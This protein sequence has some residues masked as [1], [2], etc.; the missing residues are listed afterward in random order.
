M[1]QLL[2]KIRIARADTHIMQ[3]SQKVAGG[4]MRQWYHFMPQTGWMN[5]PN[6]LIWFRDQYHLFYQYNPY[7]AFWGMMYWGHAVSN[8]LIH[9]QHLPLALAPGHFYDDHPKGGCFSGSAI[10]HDGKLW[11][12]YTGTYYQG[13]GFRQ[14]QCAAW[15]QDGIHFEKY[16]GNPVLVP[17]E[18]YDLSNF[19]DPKVF[20][21]QGKFY[22]VVGAKREG[23][24]RA[25][26]FRSDDLLHW[27]FVNV[28]A[29]SRGELGYM[30]ECPDFYPLGDNGLYVLMFSP[31]GL[32]QR[33]TLYL[34]GDM[35]FDRGIFDSHISGEVD[36]GFDY[37]APQSFLDGKGRRILIAWANAWDWMPWWKDWGPTYT[38]G[39]CGALTLPR[40]V[41][42]LPDHT[43]A[44]QPVE[45]VKGLRGPL[46]NAGTFVLEAGKTYGVGRGN[47][48]ELEFTIDLT[49]TSAGQVCVRLRCKEGRAA[50]A[51]FDLA[52]A[53]LWVDRN[54][55]DGWSKG[56]C[57][58]PMP[59]KGKATLKVRIFVDM[60]SIEIFADEGRV[61]LSLNVFA[62]PDQD[63]VEMIAQGG[64]ARI[65]HMRLWMLERAIK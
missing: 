38:E 35:D 43:L 36:W 54:N 40:Q 2:E 33:K 62:P 17:P 8:D 59:L 42:M 39:W 29:E 61:C 41:E 63:G 21:H 7:D 31:M 1:D 51:C 34:V 12:L 47:A 48:I 6:G 16:E 28:L 13:M 53:C 23:K 26:L 32:G 4:P 44:F 50:K 65:E 56:V 22:L 14:V 5:D 37:Y 20:S 64:A 55:A 18:G 52:N 24:A 57:R 49:N 60:D 19:R 46:Q 11:L 27:I 25:L 30:W 3:A 9:W 45:E 58:S 15:S 10:E